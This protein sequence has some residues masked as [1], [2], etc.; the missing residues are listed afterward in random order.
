MHNPRFVDAIL[1]WRMTWVLARLGLVSAYLIGGVT[2]LLDFPGAIA[3]QAHFGLQ[4]A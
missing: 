1:A 3:E 4:P 2:K